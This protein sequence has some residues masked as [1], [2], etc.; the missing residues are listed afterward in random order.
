VSSLGE[1]EVIGVGDG[2]DGV[3]DAAD[4]GFSGGDAVVG[5]EDRL[6]ATSQISTLGSTRLGRADDLLDDDSGF[7][8]FLWVN[9][10]AV[11][12]GQHL[13]V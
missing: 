2:D 7:D 8:E 1:L 11:G 9:W 5:V 10:V 6:S 3:V 12:R 13:L 4:D